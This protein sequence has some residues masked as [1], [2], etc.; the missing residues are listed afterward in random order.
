MSAFVRGNALCPEVQNGPFTVPIVITNL[1]PV[2]AWTAQLIPCTPGL[3]PGEVAAIPVPGTI[4]LGPLLQNNSL[5]ITVGL[6]GVSSGQLACFCIRLFDAVG[7]F[8][9]ESPVCVRLPDCPPLCARVTTLEVVCRPNGTFANLSVFNQSAAT[10][11][12]YATTPVPTGQLPPGAIT[13]QPQ[14]AGLWPFTPNLAPG[15][16]GNVTITLPPN[17]P[18]A[19]STFCFYLEFYS[20]QD[21]LICREMVCLRVPACACA[22][23]LNHDVK[24]V[25]GPGGMMVPQLT[26][27]V[28]NLTNAFG[29]P[30]SFAAATILPGAGFSPSVITPSP[31]PIPPGGTGTFTTLFTGSRPPTCLDIFLTDA[32]RKFCCPLRLCPLWVSCAQPEGPHRCDIA[33][34]F[35]VGPNSLA[36]A[37]AWICNGSNQPQ[38]FTWSVAPAAVPGCTSVLPPNAVP[39]AASSSPSPSAVPRSPPEPAPDSSSASSQSRRK[40]PNPSAA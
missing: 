18:P 31:N 8:L 2:P 24:C 28:Q 5:P 34:Q 40:R 32:A 30:F 3:Q 6:T 21:Q 29:T 14:P 27:T 37:S 20:P 13:G 9:C 22:I 16:T 25:P 1:Q 38:T 19:G 26:F 35:S 33:S 11:G 7:N 23:I 17:L 4:N 10:F 15:N 12:F 36:N 39:A